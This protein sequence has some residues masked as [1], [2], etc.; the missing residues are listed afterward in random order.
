MMDH[1]SEE[2]LYTIMPCL[3]YW[4]WWSIWMYTGRHVTWQ[5]M[6]KQ[7]HWL[8]RCW[9]NLKY[10]WLQNPSSM[11]YHHAV[12]A[13]R[14]LWLYYMSCFA[15]LQGMMKSTLNQFHHHESFL[16]ISSPL[17]VQ[18]LHRTLPT[19][20]RLLTKQRWKLYCVCLLTNE[21]WWWW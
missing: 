10:N 7:L 1:V 6:M 9:T 13:Y 11:V 21:E 18:C 15:S 17:F 12:S 8:Y 19:I 3:C 5:H 20:K 2:K 16:S 14:S 4:L